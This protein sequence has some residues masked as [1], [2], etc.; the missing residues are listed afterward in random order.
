[1]KNN[2][3]IAIKLINEEIDRLYS[4]GRIDEGMWDSI[5][6]ALAKITSIRKKLPFGSKEREAAEKQF[7]KITSKVD[8]QFAIQIN[9]LTKELKQKGFPNQKDS[10][11]F[12]GQA[13]T[14]ASI[15]DSVAAATKECKVPEEI[16]NEVISD[17]RKMLE[18]FIDHELESV[19][20]RLAEAED[21]QEGPLTGTTD[22]KANKELQSNQAPAVLAALGAL[23][24]GFGWL[25]KQPWFLALFRNPKTLVTTIKTITKLNRLG[26]TEHL[27]V[28]MG[29]PGANLS[30][31]TVGA[32]KQALR[33][34]GLVGADGNPTTNLINLARD[35]GNNNFLSW[36]NQNLA[37]T[38]HDNMTLAKAIPF[39]GAGAPGAGGDIFTSTV[40]KS[41]TQ[42]VGGGALT[43]AGAA[44]AT[45][46]PIVSALG[47]GLLASGAAVY[48]LRRHGRKYSRLKSLQAI[49]EEMVDVKANCGVVRPPERNPD[50]PT[51]E[52]GFTVPIYGRSQ[53]SI[54]KIIINFAKENDLKIKKAPFEELLG[55]VEEWLTFHARRGG[56][57]IGKDRTEF[58]KMREAKDPHNL[59][60]TDTIYV[61][62][63]GSKNRSL[64]SV[65][66]K[67]LTGQ[68]QD[69]YS[70]LRT[71]D[72]TRPEDGVYKQLIKKIVDFIKSDLESQKA[73]VVEEIEPD[74]NESKTLERWKMLS[75]SK[76]TK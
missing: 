39:S 18:F 14:I 7:D 4:E 45:A 36:W 53:E 5:K 75:E 46:A 40:S 69:L 76:R 16:G 32:M 25:I 19:Y 72:G 13:H 73:N 43:A 57:A 58:L 20:K 56:K 62:G 11:E 49:L 48:M 30:G 27:A 52:G 51:T 17:L 26:V 41:M 37:G 47:I 71:A 31:M 10:M 66:Y 22:T 23:G 67:A 61:A 15:Y 8:N 1:M 60:A 59:K 2:K 38:M 64:A 65:L 70:F 50:V 42:V 55:L 3:E 6:N 9:N 44:L 68:R 28:L 63:G 35:G 54:E 12:L 34:N 21:D 29:R 33:N 24:S 74:L